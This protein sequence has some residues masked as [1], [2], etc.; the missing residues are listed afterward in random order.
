MK[1]SAVSVVIGYMILLAITVSFISLLNAVWIPQMK[2][3]AEV[4][5]LGQV[6]QSFLS[7]ATDIDR[8][9]TFRQNSSINHRVQLGGGD[10][11]FSPVRSSGSLRVNVSPETG[12]MTISDNFTTIPFY[13]LNI[14]YIPAGNFWVEQGYLWENGT[15]YVTKI[16]SK[17]HTQLDLDD[18]AGPFISQ[19]LRP[20]MEHVGG[21]GNYTTVTLSTV[22]FSS[23]NASVSGNGFGTI[24]AGITCPAENYTNVKSI[25]GVLPE[26]GT[27]WISDLYGDMNRS[28]VPCKMEGGKIVFDQQTEVILR[29]CSFCM[30]VE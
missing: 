25:D 20:R 6:E 3:Q 16:S 13:D 14:S 22:S 15:V 4:E 18:H 9:T 7:L 12:K 1:D 10:V 2:Q 21:T 26:K 23:H 24:R 19:N 8:M 27:N 29:R 17:T 30:E 5:H 11:S 28:G